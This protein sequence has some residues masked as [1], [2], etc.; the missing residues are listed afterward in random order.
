MVFLLCV[1]GWI[2]LVA[3]IPPAKSI[4]PQWIF[5]KSGEWM[6]MGFV[7]AGIWRAGCSDITDLTI[8]FL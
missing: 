1:L 3:E 7:E 5:F 4:K 6:W 8:S 2:H